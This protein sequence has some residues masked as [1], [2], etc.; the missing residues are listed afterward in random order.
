LVSDSREKQPV[1]VEW[2]RSRRLQ[3]LI[4]LAAA[5][6]VGTSI[7]LWTPQRLFPQIPLISGFAWPDFFAW[8][9]LGLLLVSLAWLL[10][11]AVFGRSGRLPAVIFILTALG[12]LLEDQ[13]RA[14]P[15][16]LQFLWLS[17]FVAIGPPRRTLLLVVML[18]SSLYFYSAISK[19]N[20]MFLE[21][22]G[23]VILGGLFKSL[24][25]NPG[26]VPENLRRILIA[27][28]P[29]GE[30]LIAVGL[31][32][33]K[34][35]RRAACLAVFMHGLLILI[36]SPR[37]LNHEWGVLI[38]NGFFLL[39]AVCLWVFATPAEENNESSRDW[40]GLAIA[41]GLWLFPLLR[42]SGHL[43]QWAGWSLYSPRA[44]V[45]RIYL[46]VPP[47][48]IDAGFPDFTAERYQLI[49]GDAGPLEFLPD[50]WSIAATHVPLNPESRLELAVAR[51][52]CE[53]YG[54]WDQIA[55]VH[56]TRDLMDPDE[57]VTQ[58]YRKREAL[59]AFAEE[60]ALPT[61]ANRRFSAE[62]LETR[63]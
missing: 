36:F 46:A 44:D 22:H 57:R 52:L 25:L 15:W 56:E 48:Q 43:D 13:H 12:L 35:R 3:S 58:S 53:T 50:R 47:A 32:V 51:S 23:Q 21:Q 4:A 59:A 30:L 40:I 27:G 60:F 49:R 33:G 14:Q 55:V 10:I 16:M 19:C 9:I 42:F 61:M 7:Q 41:A 17:L 6:C 26:L 1:A 8:G 45:V 31:L 54:V 2:T 18:T 37:G 28:F 63:N 38:W 20:L 34:T 39:Q 29:L 5:V 11:C 24:G 62:K